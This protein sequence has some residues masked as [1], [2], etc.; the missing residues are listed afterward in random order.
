MISSSSSIMMTKKTRWLVCTLLVLAP[1]AGAQA[2]APEA[3]YIQS[4]LIFPPDSLPGYPSCHGSTLVEL[5]SGELLAAWYAGSTEGAEDTAELGARLPAGATSWSK[6]TV[7]ADTPH[8]P[9]GNPVLHLDRKGRV[10]L[11]YVTIEGLSC[12]P[13]WD[14][15]RLKC[16][17]STD[18]GRTFGQERI[19]REELGWMDRNKPIYLTNGELLLPLY[20]ERDWSSHMFIS[21][22]DGETWGKTQS[23]AAPGGNIQPTVVELGDGSLLAF[24]RTGSPRRRLWKSTSGD[25]GRTWT[26]PSEI[27]LPNPNSACDMVRLRNG[28]LVLVINNTPEGR[29]PLTVALSTDE[30]RTWNHRRNLE[31]ANG[32]FSYP[33]VVQTRDGLIHVTYTYLRKSIKHAAFDEA[34]IESK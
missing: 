19:L 24:M 26:P 14:R 4:E 7:L 32:E 33:A 28:H 22:D 25:N 8:K 31:T 17:I 23:I 3:P 27:D 2:P 12:E 6:P 11:F 9:D 20:D 29:T 15:C 10:W 18:A 13:A 34:W 1:V 30:G 5:P 21:P 16:R